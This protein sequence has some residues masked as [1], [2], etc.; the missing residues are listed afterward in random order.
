MCFLWIWEQTAIIYLYNINWLVCVTETECVYCSVQLMLILLCNGYEPPWGGGAD[1]QN[2]PTDRPSYCGLDWPCVLHTTSTNRATDLRFVSNSWWWD[3]NKNVLAVRI[4]ARTRH[5]VCD[6]VI[7]W[8]RNYFVPI[9]TYDLHFGN[10]TN[11]LSY[12]TV[13]RLSGKMV[14]RL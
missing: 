3:K 12:T 8:Y 1:N 2:G 5:H 6:C 13:L 4:T 7:F 9:C 14:F 11:Q 10:F